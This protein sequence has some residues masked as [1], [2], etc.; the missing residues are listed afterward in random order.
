MREGNKLG[1][2]DAHARNTHAIDGAR[3]SLN[4]EK[5]TY[6]NMKNLSYSNLNDKPN[7][8]KSSNC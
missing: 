3:R 1:T 6:K 2:D 8:G 5:R 7:M 4:E